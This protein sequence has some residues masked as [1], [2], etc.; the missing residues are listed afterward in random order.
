[1]SAQEPL[2]EIPGK[3][4]TPGNLGHAGWDVLHT[5]AAVYPY[6]PSP[7]QQEAFAAFLHSWSHVYACS[8]CGYHM[9]RYLK[10]NPP[11]V[12][13]KLALNRYLC[14]FHN[15]VN[16]SVKK[17]MYDCDPMTVLRRWHPT[18]PNMED[19]PTIEEQIAEQQRLE[20]AEAQKQQEE[21]LQQRQTRTSALADAATS[22]E[23]L[24]GRWRSEN[25][26][27]GNAAS[28]SHQNT[29]GAFA[30]GWGASSRRE[31]KVQEAVPAP[32]TESRRRKWW[33][34]G[35]NGG[36]GGGRVGNESPSFTHPAPS[37]VA[38]GSIG[39]PSGGSGGNVDDDEANVMA[40][41]RR[42]KA[43]MVYCPD[44]D[45]DKGE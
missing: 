24:V 40:V 14:E 25:W 42:L 38:S 4:P 34:F 30:A 9:R 10:R 27:S 41:L 11:V 20:Q 32:L 16:K 19:Q 35:N 26:K 36:G 39:S 37:S 8:H 18:F 28:D 44:K 13:D 45:K 5:A 21:E 7:L 1:M 29:A 12:T 3:C 15:T 31:E 2:K 22:Q 33:P 23:R 17:P 43:C 6:R